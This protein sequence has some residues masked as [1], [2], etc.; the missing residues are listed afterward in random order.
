MNEQTKV[1][2]TTPKTWKFYT[3]V[4]DVLVNGERL[5]NLTWRLMVTI[6][7]FFKNLHF[8]KQTEYSYPL[9]SRECH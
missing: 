1:V 4:K 3:K 2:K 5:E 7:F 8:V 6:Q 9:Y